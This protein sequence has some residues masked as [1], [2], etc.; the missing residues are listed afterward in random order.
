MSPDLLFS[1]GASFRTVSAGAPSANIF[2]K[3]C[4]ALIPFNPLLILHLVLRVSRSLIQVFLKSSTPVPPFFDIWIPVTI[5]VYCHTR[6]MLRD[7]T[8]MSLIRVN[9]WTPKAQHKFLAW[10]QTVPHVFVNHLV[11]STEPELW[12][13]LDHNRKEWTCSPEC[14]H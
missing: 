11:D 2:Y 6:H 13:S 1:L 14:R 5:T 10:R 4:S 8:L 12:P 3:V 7:I 9:K